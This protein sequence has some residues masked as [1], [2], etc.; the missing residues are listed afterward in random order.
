MAKAKKSINFEKALDQLEEIVEDMESADLS[1]DESLKSFEKGIKLTRDCQEALT[2][3][4][5]KVQT[6]IEENGEFSAVALDGAD[7]DD[8]EV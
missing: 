7:E 8:L 6:L 1:L 5:Q 2:H 4:E 3:A